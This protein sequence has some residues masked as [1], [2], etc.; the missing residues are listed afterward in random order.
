LV[1]N[2]EIVPHHFMLELEGLID[3]GSKS[4]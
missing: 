3:Q 2:A 4:G 1:E